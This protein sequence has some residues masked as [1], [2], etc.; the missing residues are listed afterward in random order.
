MRTIQPQS[1]QQK[2]DEGLI[3]AVCEEEK[4]LTKKQADGRL[5]W[6]D[7]QLP[8]RPHPQHWKD[9]AFYDE[10]HFGI[11]PQ[12]TKRMKRRRGKA[13]RYKPTNVHRKKVT[14][15]DTKAKARE[16]EPLKLL[17][18]SVAIGYNWRKLVHYI[19]PNTVGK[20]TTKVY[21]EVVLPLL[22]EDL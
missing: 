6:I 7:V 10:F 21:I 9:V 17:N 5:D 11:G 16:E 19:V 22:K 13:A 20:M 15:K 14:S 12:I 3:N 8:H 4:E 18:I 1:I 2:D